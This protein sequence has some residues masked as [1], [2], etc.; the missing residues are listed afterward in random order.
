MPFIGTPAS[1]GQSGAPLQ[2][3]SRASTALR[4]SVSGQIARPISAPSLR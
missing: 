3:S 1:H 4:Y 2:S